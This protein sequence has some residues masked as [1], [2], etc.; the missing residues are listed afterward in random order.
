M[1]SFKAWLIHLG[2]AEYTS[3]FQQAGYDLKFIAENGL[4]DADLDCVGIPPQKMGIRR[5][6]LKL[7]DLAKFYNL[8]EDDD[9]DDE[10]DEDEEEDED[11]G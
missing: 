4:Q 8:E 7:H 9:E 6:L 5:K 1:P 11:D 10:E 2:A 3:R